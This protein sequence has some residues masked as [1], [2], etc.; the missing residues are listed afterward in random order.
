MNNNGRRETVGKVRCLVYGTEGL[1][2]K[3]NQSCPEK[4]CYHSGGCSSFK[5]N[6]VA[7][8]CR[9]LRWRFLG[10]QRHVFQNHSSSASPPDHPNKAAEVAT[11]RVSEWAHTM[12]VGWTEWLISITAVGLNSELSGDAE[13]RSQGSG[14]A[15]SLSDIL[16]PKTLQRKISASQFL[17]LCT[18]GLED[19]VVWW[20]K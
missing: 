9:L 3:W 18:P 19:I 8:G 12:A 5:L 1:N 2:A 15:N 16:P 17:R 20:Q 7:T 6:K 14:V 4:P 13:L 11:G 10:I